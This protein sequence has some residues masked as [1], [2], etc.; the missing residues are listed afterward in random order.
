[1]VLT[2]PDNK[3][4]GKEKFVYTFPYHYGSHATR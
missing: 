2:Q 1:M 4:T 3:F